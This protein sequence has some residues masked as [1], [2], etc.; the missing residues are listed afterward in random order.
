MEKEYATEAL[1]MADTGNCIGCGKMVTGATKMCLD[2]YRYICGDCKSE[3]AQ[4]QESGVVLMRQLVDQFRN[5]EDH[6]SS[7]PIWPIVDKMEKLLTSIPQPTPTK[8]YTRPLA[9]SQKPPSKGIENSF[10]VLEKMA[11][12]VKEKGYVSSY[13]VMMGAIQTIKS[14][15]QATPTKDYAGVLDLLSEALGEMALYEG[16]PTD[17]IGKIEDA[18]A[19]LSGKISA[20][21]AAPG[22]EDQ[23]WWEDMMSMPKGLLVYFLDKANKK[24]KAQA[25]PTKDYAGALE[26]WK[27][28]CDNTDIPAN[29]F[30]NWLLVLLTTKPEAKPTSLKCPRCFWVGNGGQ[31]IFSQEGFNIKDTCPVCR[32]EVKPCQGKG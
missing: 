30:G 2:N 29:L 12:F 4:S 3:I 17:I 18:H 22:K 28:F 8:D 21:H 27:S 15:P 9:A 20:P 11:E 32:G 7:T 10:E 31:A 6:D 13:Y 23:E 24:C 14:Q 16:A 19:I 5:D 26:L 1:R 25:T